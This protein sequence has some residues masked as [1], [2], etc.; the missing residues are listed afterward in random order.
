[1]CFSK[2]ALLPPISAFVYHAIENRL[3]ISNGCARDR[4]IAD[5]SQNGSSPS[6]LIVLA[7]RPCTDII[8]QKRRVGF[9]GVAE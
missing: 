7:C 2:T 1:M 4:D 6:Q 8:L 5:E 9:S 3:R